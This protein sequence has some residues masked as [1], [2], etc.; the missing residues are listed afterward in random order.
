MFSAIYIKLN[1]YQ[2]NIES[3]TVKK[4]SSERIFYIW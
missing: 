2:N 3:S 1:R 4:D